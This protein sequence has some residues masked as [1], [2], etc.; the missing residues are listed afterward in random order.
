M[1]LVCANWLNE[2]GDMSHSETL[3]LDNKKLT[4]SLQ[5]LS[6]KTKGSTSM[7]GKLISIT[8]DIFGTFTQN[9]Q[10]WHLTPNSKLFCSQQ[11]DARTPI[12]QMFFVTL[13][14]LI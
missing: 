7:V 3:R 2:N 11:L 12:V 4:Q 5:S 6:L 8:L 9:T 13:N 14:S 1:W 10:I